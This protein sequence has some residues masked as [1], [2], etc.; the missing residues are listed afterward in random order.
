[1]HL[2]SNLSFEQAAASGWVSLGLDLCLEDNA[3]V[4][5]FFGH[6]LVLGFFRS[7]VVAQLFFLRQ[8]LTKSLSCPFEAQTCD[9]P[10]QL[11]TLL[12]LCM[13]QTSTALHFITHRS[14]PLQG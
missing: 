9:P 8:G 14:T 11:P 13:P 2:I 5:R 7:Q 10:P 3:S 6:N 4:W 1:M 12:K